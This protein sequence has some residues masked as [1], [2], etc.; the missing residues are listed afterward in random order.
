[1]LTENIDNIHKTVN[2]VEHNRPRVFHSGTYFTHFSAQQSKY[3]LDFILQVPHWNKYYSHT[4]AIH[5]F[6]TGILLTLRKINP[7]V[8]MRL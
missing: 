6:T 5:L 3:N 8:L 2:I 7:F 1:M 4:I